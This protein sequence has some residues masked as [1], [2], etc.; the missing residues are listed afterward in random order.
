M[1]GQEEAGE[2]ARVEAGEEAWVEARDVEAQV[3]GQQ[4]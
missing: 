1:E 4:V 2:E 3:E